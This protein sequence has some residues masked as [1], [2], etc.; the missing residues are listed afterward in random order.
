M[1]R[2]RDN[3]KLFRDR[4]FTLAVKYRPHFEQVFHF[5]HKL[6][7][8]DKFA[9]DGVRTMHA[10]ALILRFADQLKRIEEDET[11]HDA[12]LIDKDMALE[13]DKYA[14]KFDFE[15]FEVFRRRGDG[16]GIDTLFDWSNCNE[17]EPE[18][19][20]SDRHELDP[21]EC[22]VFYAIYLLHCKECS[23]SLCR[24]PGCQ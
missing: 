14:S 3:H 19:R 7:H 15:S 2:R 24:V 5:R 13:K 1:V 9:Q 22:Q 11:I 23:S 21:N 20:N 8:V 10:R 16:K 18:I 6:P 17:F 4:V 12:F